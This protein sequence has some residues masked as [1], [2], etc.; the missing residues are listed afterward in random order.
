MYFFNA[1][2]LLIIIQLYH[3][4]LHSTLLSILPNFFCNEKCALWQ[5]NCS[6]PNDS[7]SSIGISPAHPIAN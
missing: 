3:M 1:Y 6:T 2:I 5:S 4:K 7:A